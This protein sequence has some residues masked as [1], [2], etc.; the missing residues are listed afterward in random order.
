M[1][2]QNN[3]FIMRKYHLGYINYYSQE[4]CKLFGIISF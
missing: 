1:E 3:T 2:I 4:A